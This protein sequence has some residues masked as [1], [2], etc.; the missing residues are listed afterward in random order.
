VKDKNRY[1][2]G[3]KVKYRAG[4]YDTKAYE[5][6]EWYVVE[7]GEGIEIRSFSY[8]D[9]YQYGVSSI[10]GGELIRYFLE[11]NLVLVERAK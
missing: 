1:N 9:T 2:V 10:A 6:S 4:E 11:R 7:V 5:N 3:D 8:D